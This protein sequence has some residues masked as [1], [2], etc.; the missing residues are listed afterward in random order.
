[1][2]RQHSWEMVACE[3]KEEWSPEKGRLR[4]TGL[5]FPPLKDHTV[6]RRVSAVL[7]QHCGWR[8][9]FTATTCAARHG[10][11]RGCPEAGFVRLAVGARWKSYKSPGTAYV[12]GVGA[13]SRRSKF[14][15]CLNDQ[16]EKEKRYDC[17]VRLKLL[18]ML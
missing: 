4:E 13:P 11:T 10:D 17:N 5:L 1:M 16:S 7:H 2:W 9:R 8:V 12:P 3:M 14:Y 18:L 15:T 6:C